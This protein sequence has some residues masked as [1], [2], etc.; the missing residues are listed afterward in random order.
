[1]SEGIGPDVPA[2]AASISA[3]TD[4]PK[5]KPGVDSALPRFQELINKQ[6]QLIKRGMTRS[7]EVELGYLSEFHCAQMSSTQDA[8]TVELTYAQWN[9][10]PELLRSINQIRLRVSGHHT[11]GCVGASDPAP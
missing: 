1:M 3:K 2:P 8:S 10:L 7:V 6:E 9:S 5:S 11:D 4:Q